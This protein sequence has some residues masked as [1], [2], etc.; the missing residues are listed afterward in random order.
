VHTITASRALGPS[1]WLPNCRVTIEH[2]L[3]TAVEPSSADP[4]VDL[5]CPGFVDLQVN[6]ID[7]V[8]VFSA[9]GAQWDRLDSLLAAQGTTS[10][11]P[12]L[13][14][15][16]MHSYDDPL[17]R[18]DA[19][20]QRGGARPRIVGAHL[21]GPFLGGA[22]GAH[23]TELI[24]DIDLQWLSELPDIVGLVTIGAEQRQAADAAALLTERGIA[25]SIGHSTADEAQLGAVAACGASMVTHLFNGMSGLHH[26]TPGVAAWALTNPDV[27]VSLIADGVHVHPRMVLLAA[28]LLGPE[29]LVLVTDA[30]AWRAGSA[31]SLDLALEDGAPRLA[32]GTLA[33]S[34]LSMDAAVR[35]C[36]AAGVPLEWALW[37][38]SRNPA[39]VLDLDDCGVIAVGA[40]ADLVAL[41]SSLRISQVWLGGTAAR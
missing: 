26:R 21:E 16:P 9:H 3:I 24:A 18:I 37:A 10:W 11:C 1:G 13:I 34:A 22:P 30:V 31:G 40:R 33:G 35:N 8:D 6:G 36:V 23:R 27:A 19:S 41:D 12:T 29:R 39:R 5:L 4:D 2:G 28:R 15:M 38:A 25:V 20:A 32:D 14:T 17:R 7:D